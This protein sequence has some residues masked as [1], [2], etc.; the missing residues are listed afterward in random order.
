[1]EIV[2]RRA[3]PSDAAALT[4]IYNHAVLVERN[5]TFETEPRTGEERRRWID[6]VVVEKVIHENLD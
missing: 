2:V 1:M 4:A 3:I 6:C 5:S